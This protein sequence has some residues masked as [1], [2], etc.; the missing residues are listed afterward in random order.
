MGC[1]RRLD[2]VVVGEQRSDANV[3]EISLTC[4]SS[5]I[6]VDILG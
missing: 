1:K 6:M 3:K 4:Q 5:R 2:Q